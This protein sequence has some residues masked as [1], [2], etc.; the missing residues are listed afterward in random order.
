MEAG[1]DSSREAGVVME[2]MVEQVLVDMVVDSGEEME[3][4]EV[5]T[6]EARVWGEEEA[7]VVNKEEMV[8]DREDGTKEEDS[9]EVRGVAP[10]VTK[11]MNIEDSEV[12]NIQIIQ[13]SFPGR[14]GGGKM[15]GGRGGGG[16]GGPGGRGRGN[17]T[18]PY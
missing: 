1:E 14:G 11:V 17:K 12:K 15:R 16:R 6:E 7:G 13:I 3:D 5:D 9:G 4:M 8:V 18:R 2:D 10:G